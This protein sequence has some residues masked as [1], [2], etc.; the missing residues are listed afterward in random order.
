MPASATT[1]HPLHVA[2]AA[3]QH[4][5]PLAHATT[6]PNPLAAQVAQNVPPALARHTWF[7]QH[8]SWLTHGVA[9]LAVLAA[10]SLIVLLAIQTTKNEGLSGTIGGKVESAYRGRLGMDEQLARVTGVVAVLFV[11]SMTILALTGI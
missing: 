4:A 5:A 11:A 8:A 6:V 2:G 7:Q 1:T 10:I 3:T 9:G